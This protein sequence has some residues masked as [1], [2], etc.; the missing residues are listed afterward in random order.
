MARPSKNSESGVLLI[1]CS[2]ISVPN[3]IAELKEMKGS[4]DLCRTMFIVKCSTNIAK[5]TQANPRYTR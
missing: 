1:F 3:K 2:A 4:S 5:D